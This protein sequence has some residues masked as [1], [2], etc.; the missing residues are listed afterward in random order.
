MNDGSEKATTTTETEI[1]KQQLKEK[2]KTHT[3]ISTERR[4]KRREIRNFREKY[5]SIAGV[6]EFIL[7]FGF[8]SIFLKLLLLVLHKTDCCL[9]FVSHPPLCIERLPIGALTFTSKPIPY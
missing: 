7:E 9:N 6:L 1:R 2:K 5:N 4:K 3:T 8:Y